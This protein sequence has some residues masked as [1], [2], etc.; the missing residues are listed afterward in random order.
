MSQ[1]GSPRATVWPKRC[2]RASSQHRVVLIEVPDE[3]LNEFRSPAAQLRIRHGR[4]A[5]AATSQR[6][7][8]PC[9]THPH[10]PRS[11][12]AGRPCQRPVRGP[13]W[14]PTRSPHPSRLISSLGAPSRGRCDGGSGFAHAVA[15]AVGDDGVAVVQEPVEHGDRGAVF[16]QET[17]PGLEGPVAGDAEGAAFVGG[18][19][20]AEQQLR[21]GGIERGEAEFV[22]LSGHSHRS[23]NLGTFRSPRRPP[24]HC[25]R[26]S[27]SATRK[28]R[29]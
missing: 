24:P 7:P 11:R 19:D 21:A 16:G 26:S 12:P 5:T 3:G 25:S 13:H 18:G 4:T 27:A 28:A 22:D 14:W 29:S 15:V 9:S 2:S 23:M 6:N 10:R 1:P 8:W 20:E 17:A